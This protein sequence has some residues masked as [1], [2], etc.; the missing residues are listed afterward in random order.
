MDQEVRARLRELRPA[1]EKQDPGD[2]PFFDEAVEWVMNQRRDFCPVDVGEKRQALIYL[3]DACNFLRRQKATAAGAGMLRVPS[4]DNRLR[5]EQTRARLLPEVERIRTELFGKASAP[6]RSIEKASAWLERE[7]RS[8]KEKFRADGLEK[9][10]ARV[11]KIDRRIQELLD[12]LRRIWPGTV[13]FT[14]DLNT[15]DVWKPFK[16]KKGP[17]AFYPFRTYPGTRARKLYDEAKAI[18]GL[19]RGAEPAA[20]AFEGTTVRKVRDG[21]EDARALARFTDRQVLFW[22]L[23]D[24]KP[25]GIS[26]NLQIYSPITARE[27]MAMYREASRIGAAFKHKGRRPRTITARA[28]DVV[29][30]IEKLGGPPEEHIMEFWAKATK[31]WNRSRPSSGFTSR[32]GLKKAYERAA[33]KFRR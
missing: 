1:I 25:L 2:R 9:A 19:T 27:F 23:A 15:L 8:D 6:F 24:V 21:I 4:A 32:D 31:A 20:L 14:T 5:S 30:F 13:K 28:A 16:G 29:R 22:I 11:L 18:E 17:G 10:W 12:E 7:I 26:A 33:K 3:K